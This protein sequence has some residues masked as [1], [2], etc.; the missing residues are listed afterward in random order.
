MQGSGIEPRHHQKNQHYIVEEE[1]HY[2]SMEKKIVQKPFKDKRSCTFNYFISF[3]IFYA[4]KII[5]ICQKK[6]IMIFFF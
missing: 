5:M 6:I 3:T 1:D 2:K 4:F